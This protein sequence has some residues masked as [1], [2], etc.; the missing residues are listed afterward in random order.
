MKFL[1]AIQNSLKHIKTATLVLGAFLAAL[2]AFT[3]Y[4]DNENKDTK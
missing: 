2:T 1:T 3:Q 4:W